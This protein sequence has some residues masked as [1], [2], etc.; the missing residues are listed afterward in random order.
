VLAPGV[1]A[2]IQAIVTAKRLVV[3]T[4]WKGRCKRL[5]N[6]KVFAPATSHPPAWADETGQSSSRRSCKSPRQIPIREWSGEPRPVARRCRDRE[7][8]VGGRLLGKTL[9]SPSHQNHD[10]SATGRVVCGDRGQTPRRQPC[11]LTMCHRRDCL[12]GNLWANRH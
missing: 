10:C 5:P 8:M 7:W 2:D 12:V 9:T 3:T 11:Q 6:H 4:E 1:S